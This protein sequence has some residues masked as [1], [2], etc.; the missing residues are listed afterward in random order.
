[1][2]SINNRRGYRRWPVCLIAALLIF[3]LGRISTQAQ[4]RK[5]ELDQAP[6]K[7][8]L[9]PG[10]MASVGTSGGSE[11]APGTKKASSASWTRILTDE[12]R[13]ALRREESS[14]AEAAFL[15]YVNNFFATTRLGPEDVLTVDVFD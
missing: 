9:K 8:D 4:E 10:G 14:E 2:R 15:P 7:Q 1:M 5:S 3:G 6:V 11:N 12:E 13:E